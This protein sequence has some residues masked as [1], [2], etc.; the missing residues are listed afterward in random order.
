MV[1]R[2]VRRGA[3]AR[4][5]LR[6]FWGKSRGD[7]DDGLGDG[8]RLAVVDDA[9]DLGDYGEDGGAARRLKWM[10]STRGSRD[11][12]MSEQA[13]VFV[14]AFSRS[15]SAGVM[16][17]GKAAAGAVRQIREAGEV[18]MDMHAG[19]LEKVRFRV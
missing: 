4:L 7:F 5:V 12:V 18:L 2:A 3:L 11:S 10:L 14:D 16:K 17:G 13:A 15:S 1:A 19:A 9:N 6:A 8:R